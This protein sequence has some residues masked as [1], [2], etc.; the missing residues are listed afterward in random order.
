MGKNKKIMLKLR[1]YHTD[2]VSSVNGGNSRIPLLISKA[3]VRRSI[4]ALS[5]CLRILHCLF[6]LLA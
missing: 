2:T 3:F 4:N 1:Y 5:K 6:A